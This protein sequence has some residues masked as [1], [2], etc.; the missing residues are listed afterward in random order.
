MVGSEPN[1]VAWALAYIKRLEA[2][3][4][5]CRCVKRIEGTPAERRAVIRDAIRKE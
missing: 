1:E 2:E 5:Q 4:A 3:L